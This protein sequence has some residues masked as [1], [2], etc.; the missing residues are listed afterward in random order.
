MSSHS[1]LYYDEWLIQEFPS[2]PLHQIHTEERNV[3]STGPQGITRFSSASVYWDRL[4]DELCRLSSLW[5][6]L[7]CVIKQKYYPRFLHCWLSWEQHLLC[8]Q[9]ILTRNQLSLCLSHEWYRCYCTKQ[10]NMRAIAWRQ[11]QAHGNM[12]QLCFINIAVY[13]PNPVK[14]LVCPNVVQLQRLCKYKNFNLSSHIYI[15]IYFF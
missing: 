14:G 15:F 2:S 10:K 9:G 3:D 1:R 6:F 7:E 11:T 12:F 4:A 8:S 5:V 13:K